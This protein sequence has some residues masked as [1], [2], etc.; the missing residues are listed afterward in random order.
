MKRFR[1]GFGI[2]SKLVL[3]SGLLLTIPWLGYE[4]VSEMEKFLRQGQEK[5][6]AGTARAVA[7]AL[8]DR[9]KLFDVADA[10][11]GHSDVYVRSLPA[12]IQLDGRLDDWNEHGDFARSYGEGDLLENSAVHT[13]ASLSFSHNVGRLGKY[14]YAMFLVNDNHIV[15]RSTKSPR[16][17]RGDHL[18]VA[19]ATR[20]SGFT[21]YAV[22]LAEGGAI[23]AY[24]LASGL[25]TTQVVRVETRLRGVW[26]PTEQGYNLE[27]RVPISMIGTR[28]GFAVADVDNDGTH[29]IEAVIGTSGTD[30]IE[31][32]ARVFIPSSEIELILKGLMRTTSRIW[33]VDARHRVLAQAGSLKG[34]DRTDRIAIAPP[35][36]LM[37][38]LQRAEE[39]VL[40]PV[41]ARVLR[42]PTDDFR[43]ELSEASQLAGREIAG[44]LSGSLTTRWRLTSDNRAV[45]LSA[46]HPI[47]IDDQVMGAVVVE[48][49]TNAILTVKNLALERLFTIILAVF[50]IGALTLFIFAARISSRIRR[51]RDEAERA[52]DAQGRF[53]GVM[54]RSRASDE[55]GDLSRSFSSIMDKLHQYTGYLE[56]MATRLSHELRTPIAV[57]RSSLDNL[58]LQP[59]PD[60]A[61]VYMERAQDGLAR[62]TSILTSMSEAT[63]LEQILQNS[64]RERFDLCK[65]VAGCVEGYKAAYTPRA[66]ELRLPGQTVWL[67]GAPDLIAQLLD[68]LI[69]NAIDFSR[70]NSVI[71]V[72]IGLDAADAYLRVINQ[73]P[74]LPKEMQERLFESMVSIRPHKGSSEPHLGL[75]LYIVRLI[76]GFHGGQAYAQNHHDPAGVA[77]TVKLPIIEVEEKSHNW[78]AH[79]QVS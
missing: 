9:P 71:V 67:N 25:D 37:H 32:L 55:I 30:T 24:Q 51:L 36:G 78:T 27:I 54:A 21:R 20:D 5:T 15:L 58:K 13:P 40:R 73:G 76:A 26:R 45:I 48:E 79:T 22:T 6:L 52:I 56:S 75:G 62:L 23:A 19:I 12:S 29:E 68:K 70:A 69:E 46:A 34:Q 42:Q 63:R 41:Y 64:E 31:E 28:V 14:L 38:V 17:D 11:V 74:P 61:R 57:V 60:E 8:H 39:Q 50:L 72:E 7:T 49:T 77:V 1:Y 59:L 4:Y 53:R 43:D 10:T 47:W 2:R 35:T 65:V 3:L 16:V 33:V 44:A 66:I 18:R